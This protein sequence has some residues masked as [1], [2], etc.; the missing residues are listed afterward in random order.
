MHLKWQY[1]LYKMAQEFPEIEL[2]PDPIDSFEVRVV[3]K[4][5]DH[6]GTADVVLA[7]LGKHTVVDFK[8]LNVRSFSKIARGSVP[9][10]YRIQLTD[11]MILLNSEKPRRFGKVE[12]ALL[13]AENKGGPD[14][15]HPA[16]LCETRISLKENRAEVRGRLEV[17]R[18]YEA[19]EEIPPPECVSTKSFQFKGCPFQGFCK[20]EVKEI[21]RRR[22]KAERSDSNGYKVRIPKRGRDESLPMK[23][24]VMKTMFLLTSLGLTLN[25]LVLFIAAM[26]SDILTPYF[27]LLT[28]VSWLL[29]CIVTLEYLK[30]RKEQSSQIN[31]K[32]N[33][34]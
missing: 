27:G 26:P 29:I 23:F 6:G 31:T 1:A 32:R 8:G 5:G 7:I 13:I 20:E 2:E 21:E 10:N 14:T 3:S 18:K 24:Q 9:D 11:Y 30:L 25:W 34:S 12:D 15:H 33:G 4:R 28:F 22:I 19:E 17:L 16:A